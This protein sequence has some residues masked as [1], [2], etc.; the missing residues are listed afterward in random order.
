MQ[1]RVGMADLSWVTVPFPHIPCVVERAQP[2]LKTY[3]GARDS[4]GQSKK[5]DYGHAAT[6][7][8]IY[9]SGIEE[10]P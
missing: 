5:N 1:D 9:C 7:K 10:K 4:H 3:I 2:H 8:T 6:L